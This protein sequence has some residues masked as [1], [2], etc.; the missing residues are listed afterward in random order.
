MG[1]SADEVR[2]DIEDTRRDMSETIDAI[3]DRT[4]P[5][6]VIRRRRERMATGFRSVKNRVMGQADSG[7]GS[8]GGQVRSLS[9]GAQER[10][11]DLAGHARQAP[12]MVM[13][14]TQGNPLAAGVIAFGA[15]LLAA[16]LVPPSEAEQRLAGKLS[17]HAQPLQDE[18]RQ[19]GEQV[20]QDLKGKAQEGAEQVKSRA[21]DAAATV[22]EDARGSADE[23]KA[24][25]TR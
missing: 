22:Q 6:R 2:A 4:S 24:K 19:A 15:G 23:V 25:A 3:A 14:Q 11:G 13:Q 12:D 20:A 7:Y 8:A 5:Q 18:M 9:E 10:A 16:S 17:E 1:K 21:Q